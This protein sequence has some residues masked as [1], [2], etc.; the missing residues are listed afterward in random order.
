M[1]KGEG[2]GC[3]EERWRRGSMFGRDVKEI[4][5]GNLAGS[6]RADLGVN[7]RGGELDKSAGERK[8]GIEGYGEER[9]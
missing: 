7:G 3:A 8:A 4:G 5:K 2:V 9:V 1:K 6:G